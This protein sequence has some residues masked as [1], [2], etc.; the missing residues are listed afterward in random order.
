[1]IGFMWCS[2]R[3][4]RKRWARQKPSSSVLAR[5]IASLKRTWKKRNRIS[6]WPRQVLYTISYLFLWATWSLKCDS[7]STCTTSME[8]VLSLLRMS[9]LWWV[10]CRLIG[11]L[12]FNTFSRWSRIELPIKPN[13]EWVVPAKLLFLGFR[14][15]PKIGKVYMMT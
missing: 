2:R 1:M 6:M 15:E 5:L 10:I 14:W 7:H 8:M 13:S 4:I 3:L 12:R 11:M 9:E